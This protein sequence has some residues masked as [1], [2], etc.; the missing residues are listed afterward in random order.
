MAA[1]AAGNPRAA[2]VTAR[3]GGPKFGR[4]Q[5]G[6]IDK[7]ARRIE[8]GQPATEARTYDA[9]DRRRSLARKQHAIDGEQKRARR[10][11]GRGRPREIVIERSG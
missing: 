5:G 7:K 4:G 2:L 9:A 6:G 11:G 3:Y 1:A 10:G 8:R